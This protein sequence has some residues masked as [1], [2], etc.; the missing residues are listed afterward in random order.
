MVKNLRASFEGKYLHGCWYSVSKK[1]RQEDFNYGGS[2]G[3]KGDNAAE[4]CA[5]FNGKYINRCWY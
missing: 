5:I 3:L 4:T 1:T 2:K